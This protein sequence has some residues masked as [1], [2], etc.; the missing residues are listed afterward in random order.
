MSNV[1]NYLAQIQ[2][3]DRR[4]AAASTIRNSPVRQSTQLG[5][6]I[7]DTPLAAPEIPEADD[8]FS[9]G[10]FVKG[11][12]PTVL[13]ALD[14][15]RAAIASGAN[16]LLDLAQGE[17]FDLGDWWT[18]T[19]DNI[20]FGD[21]IENNT[22]IDNI[23]VKRGLG[24]VGDVALDPLS[25]LGGASAVV[26][27]GRTGLAARAFNA[28]DGVLGQRILNGGISAARAED[29]AKLSKFDGELSKGVFLNAPLLGRRA[30]DGTRNQIRLT[31][32][33]S[34]Q[35][36]FD[37]L[38]R[39]TR[40][41]GNKV[42]ISDLLG[43]R[44]AKAKQLM[45]Y[46]T[47]EQATAAFQGVRAF[48]EQ[49]A[50]LRTFSRDVRN[51]GVTVLNAVRQAGPEVEQLVPRAL[52]GDAAAVDAL[53]EAAPGLF[54]QVQEFTNGLPQ[55]ANA[56]VRNGGDS[57]DVFQFREN[58]HGLTTREELFD[59]AYS[60]GRRLGPAGFERE[61]GLVPGGEFL[62]TRLDEVTEGNSI[63][64][65]VRRIIEDNNQVFGENHLEQL[66]S[67]SWVDSMSARLQSYER[68]VL[69]RSIEQDLIGKG[70]A[71]R[72]VGSVEDIR[73]PK[74]VAEANGEIASKVALENV[75][76][77]LLSDQL[78]EQRGG[79][80][81]Q[82]I[83]Q[84]LDPDGVKA[85]ERA[86]AAQTRLS[87]VS[88][89]LDGLRRRRLE[90]SEG[91][92]DGAGTGE[93]SRVQR[94]IDGLLE[95]QADAIANGAVRPDVPTTRTNGA[96][97]NPNG[98]KWAFQASENFG[99]HLTSVQ[100]AGPALDVAANNPLVLD[101]AQEITEDFAQ[102]ARANGHDAVIWP[103]G[104]D[105]RAVALDASQVSSLGDDAL[106]PDWIRAVD[107]HAA[108]LGRVGRETSQAIDDE[109]ANLTH[110]VSQHRIEADSLAELAEQNRV[111]L[112]NVTGK[113]ERLLREASRDALDVA[114][115]APTPEGRAAASWTSV[116]DKLAADIEADVAAGRVKLPTP[117]QALAALKREDIQ[118]SF[119]V[120]AREGLKD[121]SDLS[122]APEG[123]IEALESATKLVGDTKGL[124]RYLDGANRV[125][126]TYAVLTPGFHFR[127]FLGG[128]FNNFLAG[129]DAT[130]YAPFL[131]AHRQYVRAL[132]GGATTDQAT[133]RAI[134]SLNPEQAQAFRQ[135]VQYGQVASAGRTVDTDAG[136]DE[137]EG[138]IAKGR[139]LGRRA[140]GKVVENAATRIGFRAGN[141]TE[142]SLRGV[143]AFDSFL[144]GADPSEAIDRV[145]KF[146]FDYTDLS[147]F[148]QNVARRVVPFYT[149]SRKNFPLQVEGLLTNPKAYNRI[150]HLK[151]NVELG[152]EEEETV[153]G[154]VQESL[155]IRTPFRTGQLANVPGLG[156][157][158]GDADDRIYLL[159][160]LPFRELTRAVDPG[161]IF[162]STS[163]FIKTPFER[164]FG[165][166]SFNNV[167]FRLDPQRVPEA[168]EKIGIAQALGAVGLA[169]EIDGNYYARDVDI[170][171]VEQAW[172]P[173][174]RARRLF[175]TDDEASFKDRQLTTWVNFLVGA[176]AFTNTERAI[177][178]EL[179]RRELEQREDVQYQ[180]ALNAIAGS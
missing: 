26:K 51:Q 35:R 74:T 124:V 103:D 24:F 155:H 171:T 13:D 68:A 21:V 156:G 109:I 86:A 73:L 107:E 56:H 14:T 140:R 99:I 55:R 33:G 104:E 4:S 141:R 112:E 84:V 72:K 90:L 40:N 31:S 142:D 160:D 125:F 117:D 131:G 108:G 154:Y 23:W 138:F 88:A 37:A 165:K 118:Q 101:A 71:V 82:T 105:F 9:F 48:G 22:N 10:N 151:R 11:I 87:E 45:L 177:S 19:R 146:H 59:F 134:K 32:R 52:G 12:V 129:V 43:G 145:S 114:S 83:R 97:A 144:K 116:A 36:G 158:I 44:H 170:H 98:G 164:K 76:V 80:L 81:A 34:G 157:L 150:A 67:D 6:N 122:L 64:D 3:L 70:V 39:V 53:E 30:A 75:R 167:P 85:T 102:T 42:G 78:R 92:I 178:N 65:Q 49:T 17:G 1:D 113:R 148:E 2:E 50:R 7:F 28:G 126:K 133:A 54:S 175:P 163:P 47:P 100:G 46:G 41:F 173:L 159:P 69:N 176:G 93:L 20:G 169:Q 149:W 8:G 161:E 162:G 60:G 79:E 77:R 130:N 29:L 18:Q 115:S 57:P 106:A 95:D 66:F 136:F 135:T 137:L 128:T 111:S 132:N 120:L 96:L 127:N 94:Q 38:A 172:A 179:F 91:A 168:W 61:A 15:P 152:V 121:L 58:W 25:Y 27:L 110:N 166:K 147:S 89:E 139:N 62:G 153:P 174:A 63:P 5:N 180:S 123:A 16:E 119:E 143:M